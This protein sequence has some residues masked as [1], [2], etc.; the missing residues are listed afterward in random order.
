MFVSLLKLFLI[1]R[2]LG[3]KVKRFLR[4]EWFYAG[5]SAQ[6]LD[7]AFQ[8]NQGKKP[9]GE[10]HKAIL[11]PKKPNSEIV[12]WLHHLH[13]SIV[14]RAGKTFEDNADGRFS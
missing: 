6:L 9:L 12:N 8:G 2:R 7:Y 10:P 11:L 5:L 14:W 4:H 1:L 13:I 3:L